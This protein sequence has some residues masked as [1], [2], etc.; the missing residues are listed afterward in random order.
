MSSMHYLQAFDKSQLWRFFVDGRFQKKYNG[1]IGYEAG[2]RGSVQAL[3]NGFA[4]MLE[5]FDLSRG[6]SS[7]YLLDLHKIC[8]LNVETSNLKSSPGDLRYLNAG[9][10]FFAKSTTYGNLRQILRER[11][12]DGTVI[13]NTKKYA[14]TADEFDLDELYAGLLEDKRINYRNWYPNLDRRTQEALEKK[15]GLQAFY[16]AKHAVQMLFAEKMDEIVGRFNRTIRLAKTEEEKLDCFVLLVRHLELLHPFPDGNCRTFACIT[17]NHLLLYHD[18]MPTILYNPNYDGEL[19]TEEFKEEIR[20]GQALMKELLEDPE[21]AVYGYSITQM[22]EGDRKRFLEMAKETI[23]KIDGWREVYLTPER[24]A[25]ICDGRWYRADRHIRFERV[26]DYNTYLKG[27]L[28]FFMALEEWEKE[29][30]DIEAELRRLE[31]KG[32]RAIVTDDRRV[33]ETT[34]LPVMLVRDVKAAYTKAAT[35]TRQEVDPLTLLIT[36]TEGKTGAKSQLYQLLS[37]QT[38]V[39]AH[40]NSANTA[41]PVLRSLVNLT[42]E[43]R[44]ELNEVS[45]GGNEA[46]RIERSEWVNPDLCLFTHIGPNH[47]DMHKTMENLVWAKS[48]VVVGM[49][50]GGV[51]IVNSDMEY[52]DALCAAIEK[53]RPGTPVVTFGRS[54]HDDAQLLD[55]VFDDEKN[56]WNVRARVG[57]TEYDYFVPLIQGH[58]PPASVGMLLCVERMGYDVE[59]AA[60]DYASV[61]PYATMGALRVLR[62]DEGDVLFYDQ[63]RRGGIS[64]MRSAFE[65][66][67]RLKK[68][69]RVIALVGGISIKKDS[70]WTREAHRALA[71]MIDASP[72]ERLYT[73]GPFMGYVHDALKRREILV[74]HTDDLDR[75]AKRLYDDA[76]P[77]DTLFV[78]G[79]AWLYLGRVVDRLEKRAKIT[80][81]DYRKTYRF[82]PPPLS[83]FERARRRSGAGDAEAFRGEVAMRFFEKVK[84]LMTSRFGFECVDEALSGDDR[85][86]VYDADKCRAW[87][88]NRSADRQKKGR[89]LFG[90]FFDTGD[91]QWL[92]HVHLAT[93]DLHLGFVRCERAGDGTLKLGKVPEEEGAEACKTFGPP[94]GYR[95]WWRGWCSVDCGRAIDLEDDAAFALLENFGESACF[96]EVLPVLRRL[97][98]KSGD[99]S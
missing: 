24:A 33:L 65:D 25:R 66:L 19:S 86:Y 9:M 81:F 54:A 18:M 49:R 2:E 11:R 92:L 69:G 10:P 99:A 23:E 85:R 57:R 4:F 47:M 50:E 77:G 89:Q 68:R 67:G 42:E 63:S 79:S 37:P 30:R 12:G 36:G 70:E 76:E 40:I 64:G 90:T 72:V 38:K 87:F 5:H 56:G 59:R 80:R 8:M 21:A 78:I 16:H 41:I 26:G 1:W 15:R 82:D 39:H 93:T 32:V 88:F 51:C 83:A 73:T 13:F 98:E 44:V 35:Q 7:T 46:L 14:K 22:A 60:R 45:V 97:A 17:L 62:K 20:K 55:A 34:T 27:S 61:T 58:V 52:F 71:E 75:L 96:A 94:F 74:E 43:D 53:R 48:S 3:M 31:E 95:R 29:G 6:L 28:Y 84:E 91:G